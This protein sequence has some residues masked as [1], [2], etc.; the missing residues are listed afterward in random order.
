MAV[1]SKD[2]T[3]AFNTEVTTTPGG[4][5]LSRCFSCGACSGIC[6]V[7]QAIP[8]FDPRKI[9][10]MIRMGL[11][12]KLLSSNLLWYCS[13]CQSCVFVCPQDVR[14]AEIVKALW[15]MALDQDYISEQ[16]LLDKGKAAWVERD[17]CVS[18][19]TCVRVCPWQIPQMDNQGI[20]AI[21]ARTCRA[22]GICVA[23]CPAQAIQLNQS[24][25]ERLIAACGSSR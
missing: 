8:E 2:I 1:T 16:D 11:K 23:E 20:A 10:H 12:D 7:S 14:F 22:C 18:C 9:I 15:Q 3:P 17:L 4:A 19:L 5:F 25:D 24:E 13:S 6:P 21:D